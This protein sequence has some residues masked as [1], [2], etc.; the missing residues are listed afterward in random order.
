MGVVM[1][2]TPVLRDYFK[3]SEFACNCGKCGKGIADMQPELLTKLTLAR[4]LAGV[5]F[6]LNSAVRCAY[7]NKHERGEKDSAHLTGWAVDIRTPSSSS[8]MAIVRAALAVGFNRIGIYRT[9][10]HVDC[11][12]TKPKQV[13]WYGK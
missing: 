3:D 7:W 13:M 5:P 6:S 12:P 1:N 2:R 11:D 8:R 9:F 10:V 4:D